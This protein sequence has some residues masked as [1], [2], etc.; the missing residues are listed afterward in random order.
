MENLEV[1]KASIAEGVLP[2]F[3]KGQ[4]QYPTIHHETRLRYPSQWRLKSSSKCS[5]IKMFDEL[6]AVEASM[7][8]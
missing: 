7:C 4:H 6:A 3:E 8:K 2:K 5:Q 1:G